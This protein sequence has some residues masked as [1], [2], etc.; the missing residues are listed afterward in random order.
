M[1]HGLICKGKDFMMVKENVRQLFDE[2]DEAV[3][4]SSCVC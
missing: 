3:Y 1:L 4:H 2:S